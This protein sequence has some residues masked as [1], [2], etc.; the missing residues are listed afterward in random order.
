MTAE[1]TADRSWM[2]TGAVVGAIVGMIPG[3]YWTIVD[4]RNVALYLM[5]TV[6]LVAILAGVGALVGAALGRSR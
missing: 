4:G 6:V 2:L 5:I 1:T 3:A